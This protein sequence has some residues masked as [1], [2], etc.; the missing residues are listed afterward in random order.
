M[1][2]TPLTPKA[3]GLVPLG[4]AVARFLER[5]RDQPATATT[6]GE[7]VTHLLAV[8]GDVMPVA[9]LTPELCVTVMR[10]WDQRAPATWN[11]HLATLGH[12][13][14]LGEETSASITAEHDTHNRRRNC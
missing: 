10:R 12:Y 6:Y 5:Y 8:A 7:T 11:K 9:A 2:V 3:G 13:V 1:S 14:R 4:E